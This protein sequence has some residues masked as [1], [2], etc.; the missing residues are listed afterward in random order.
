MIR[1]A[2]GV[3]GFLFAASAFAECG[4]TVQCIGVGATPANAQTGGAGGAHHDP[5]NPQDMGTPTFTLTFPGSQQTG[6][7]SASQTI[8]VAAVNGPPGSTAMAA[9]LPITITGADAAHF[10][11]TGGN[12]SPSNGPVHNG[13]LCTVTV[14]FNPFS[15]GT[16]SALV[17][18]PLDGAGCVGCIVGRSVA[19]TGTAFGPTVAAPRGDP[20]RDP[21]VVAAIRAQ[22]A[23]SLRFSRAQVSNYAQRLEQLRGNSPEPSSASGASTGGLEASTGIWLGGNLNFGRSTDEDMASL[24]FRTKGLTVG[25]D[26]RLGQRFTVG[27][28]VGLARDETDIGTDGSE[29]KSAGRSLALYASYRPTTS[30]FLDVM[31]GTG[32]I[33][34]KTHRVVT[35]TSASADF[36]RDGR[37]TF[38]AIAAGYEWRRQG[39]LLSP[40]VR[41][42]Y[43]REKL[44]EATETVS[45]PIAPLTYFEQTISASQAS[46]GLRGQSRH[47]TN[48]G[49]AQPRARI[50]W[51][52]DSISDRPA[53][54]AFADQLGTEFS[55]S[56]LD[57]KRSSVLFGV[58][59]DF[60]FR[61]GLTIGVDYQTQRLPGPDSNQAIRLWL[62]QDLD[63]RAPGGGASA[64]TFANP[65]TVEAAYLYD[66]NLNRAPDAGPKLDDHVFSL[67]AGT[68][69]LLPLTAHTRFLLSPFVESDKLY[70]YDGL[71]RASLGTQADLQYRTSAAF[72]AP[73]IALFGR[74]AWDDYHSEL[75]SGRRHSVGLSVRQSWTDRIDVFAAIARNIRNADNAVWD[76]RD[77]SVRLNLDYAAGPGTLYLGGQYSGGDAVSSVGPGFESAVAIKAQV[78]D[79]AY[80]RTL[81]ANRYTARTWVGTLGY[82]F[83]LGGRDS[84]DL[85][86]RY[87]HAK[88]LDQ[89][90]GGG[91]Y[92]GGG[93]VTYTASQVLV[94][95]LTRF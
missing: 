68:A 12:C 69:F 65:I 57:T 38:G 89:L 64:G 54:V 95:Y 59:T 16:K 32:K 36:D 79:D 13:A 88:P 7:T 49:W 39:L 63:G 41:Y 52:R 77:T 22:Q 31:V 45:G 80:G 1:W 94:S 30:L 26:T 92:S 67:N 34:H 21:T 28:G 47:E 55:I 20:S 3:L 56:P 8:H 23:A 71:D 29:V 75:R 43:S 15:A 17:N 44:D 6:T 78:R 87:A 51:V 76:T 50:E 74:V 42:A 91:G 48:F 72:T 53:T 66:S 4:G 27:L 82:N 62:S 11:V 14:A 10:S 90:G 25:A 73:T 84:L 86:W 18:V 93:E 24:R 33:E 81:F 61:R 37:Q 5:S 83:P 60:V 35:V 58:G 2:A 9:L 70:R 85:S 40:Y 19:V 46:I